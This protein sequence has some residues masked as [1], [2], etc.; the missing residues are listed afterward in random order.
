[1]KQKVITLRVDVQDFNLL[2]ETQQNL[3]TT[4]LNTVIKDLIFNDYSVYKLYDRSVQLQN[5]NRM[6]K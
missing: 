5:N 4:S 3:K 2:K 6:I 1:M